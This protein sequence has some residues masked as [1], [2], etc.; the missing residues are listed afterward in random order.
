MGAN[1]GG[2][3][4]S[5]HKADVAEYRAVP[6]SSRAMLCMLIRL[7]RYPRTVVVGLREH[8]VWVKEEYSNVS[9]SDFRIESYA[10]VTRSSELE[11]GIRAFARCILCQREIWT[12]SNRRWFEFIPFVAMESTT[13]QAISHSVAHGD[14]R[15]HSPK[16]SSQRLGSY[17]LYGAWILQSG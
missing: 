2:S 4:N 16:A 9:E 14:V 8:L 12:S 13:M 5:A 7:I 15:G 6:R 3:Q 11:T 17:L 1:H 10:V